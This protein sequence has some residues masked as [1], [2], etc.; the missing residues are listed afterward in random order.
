MRLRNGRNAHD[1]THLGRGVEHDD[2][3]AACGTACDKADCD[4]AHKGQGLADT[5]HGAGHGKRTERK[6]KRDQGMKSFALAQMTAALAGRKDA[7]IDMVG[8][9]HVVMSHDDKRETTVENAGETHREEESRAER[10]RVE[11][12]RRAAQRARQTERP[13]GMA[14]GGDC[15]GPRMDGTRDDSDDELLFGGAAGRA[16][17]ARVGV[18]ELSNPCVPSQSTH[19]VG[20]GRDRA[21]PVRPKQ[22]KQGRGRDRAEPVRPK[23]PKQVMQGN[24]KSFSSSSAACPRRIRKG[25]NGIVF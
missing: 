25:R 22:P 18:V 15:S 19:T 9:V 5:S 21:E 7:R 12:A 13:D 10:Q 3:A 8:G 6:R 11:R 2:A 24:A 14:D 16:R 17:P 20:R 4:D 1:A 23:Q